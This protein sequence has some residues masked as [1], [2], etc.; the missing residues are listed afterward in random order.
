VINV[1]VIIAARQSRKGY[2]ESQTGIDTQDEDATAW[3][4]R[5]GYNVVDVV[6]DRIC[7][8]VVPGRVGPKAGH[9]WP[10]ARR[11]QDGR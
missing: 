11:L 1:D 9:G 8:P 2:G 4:K 6:A 10:P 5:R 7:R 3:A